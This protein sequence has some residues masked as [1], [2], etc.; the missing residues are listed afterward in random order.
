MSSK[1]GKNFRKYVRPHDD[2]RIAGIEKMDAYSWADRIMSIPRV[3]PLFAEWQK[4]YQESEFYGITSDGERIDGLFELADE[5]APVEAMVLAANDL[6]AQLS[7]AQK[8]TLCHELDAREWRAWMNPEVYMHRFGLRLEE[9]EAGL[10]ESILAV[11]ESSLS[12]AG[13]QKMRGLMQINHFLGELVGGP[14][15]LNEYS[16]NFNLFGKPDLTSPWGWTFYGHHVCLSCL[17]IGQQMVLTPVFFG[18]EPDHIDSG[19]NAGLRV[20]EAEERGALELMRSL[21]PASQK[22]AL[23]YHHKRDPLMPAGR[24]AMADEL[25]LC[26]AFQDNRVVPLEGTPASGFSSESRERLLGLIRAY[27][28]Y[29]PC[30][31][32]EARMRDVEQHLDDTWFCWIGGTDDDSPFYYRIQSPVLIIEFDHQAGI[33]LSNTEPEKFH[34]HTLIRTPNGNDYGMALLRQCCNGQSDQ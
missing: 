32:L 29:L 20:F 13:Y 30:G 5:G 14:G 6:L 31:P 26:G 12:P 10:R 33:F 2:P 21:D 27:L 22:L 8:Q 18:A 3:A 25:H 24:V 15:V 4:R 7:P 28:N 19:P 1:N 17:V 9:I 34:I 11:I 16:Y 23:L